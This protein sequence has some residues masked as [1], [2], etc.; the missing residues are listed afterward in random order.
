MLRFKFE[1]WDVT[2]RFD[3]LLNFLSSF[4]RAAFDIRVVKHQI[5][6]KSSVIT[7]IHILTPN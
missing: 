2:C 6:H 1:Y 3:K 5:Y 7:N 4:G